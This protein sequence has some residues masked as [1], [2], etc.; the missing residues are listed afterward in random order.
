MKAQVISERG[1]KM[2]VDV[3]YISLVF[4][5]FFV[6]CEGVWACDCG[7]I[8]DEKSADI[9]FIGKL[10]S[11]SKWSREGKEDYF[12]LPRIIKYTFD[13]IKMRKGPNLTRIIV[14]A[15]DSKWDCD[16]LPLDVG[17]TYKIY[18]SDYTEFAPHQWVISACGLAEEIPIHGNE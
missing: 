11:R 7:I 15:G 17:K 2:R 9:A 16:A 1:N 5:L 6:F 10:T 18:A 4:I 8:L 14:E 13:V 12:F 3:K